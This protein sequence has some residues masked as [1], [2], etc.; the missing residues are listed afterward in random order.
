MI[1][2]HPRRRLIALAILIGASFLGV[3]ARLA[4]LQAFEGEALA[5]QAVEMRRRLEPIRAP[6]GRI[7]DRRGRVLAA[8]RPV[9]RIAL[10]LE[11]LDPGT[12]I[13]ERVA[14][15]WRPRRELERRWRALEER[16][17]RES[18]DLAPLN[19]AA[20]ETPKL[21]ARFR[22]LC[23]EFPGLSF[24]GRTLSVSRGLLLQRARTL[25]RLARA[26]ALDEAALGER[27]EGETE[28]AL[29]IEHPID[30]RERL[31][32]PL[33]VATDI[34]FDTAAWIEEQWR[35]FP[36]VA[37][38]VALEREYPFGSI[39][40][41]LVGYTGP[42]APGDVERLRREGRLLDWAFWR[43]AD[44]AG[45][46]ARREGARFPDDRIGRAGIEASYE[47]I[48][49][50][51][52]GARLVE[53]DRKTREDRTIAEVP[54]VPGTD[55]T[56]A[57][58]LDLQRAAEDALD[59][60][61]A[62]GNGGAHGGALVL[63]DARSGEALALAT[64][65][66][67]DP[68]AIR[69]DYAALLAARPSPLLD[70][71]LAAA[72]PPGSTMKPLVAAAAL[73]ERIALEGG[74]LSPA[75][76]VFCRGH[77][78]NPRAFRCDARSGHGPIA[79]E[80]AIGQSCNVYF[81]K[82]GERL[83]EAGLGT[84][85]ARF[86]L[87]RPTEIDLPGEAAGLLPSGA[88]KR[89]RLEAARRRADREE[90]DLARAGADLAA[91]LAGGGPLAPALTGLAADETAARGGRLATARARRAHLEPEVAW[92]AGDSRNTAIGQ[93]DLLATPIQ[94][95]RAAAALGNGGRLLRPR[96]ARRGGANGEAPAV[97]AV[98]PLAPGTLAAVR[99]GMWAVVASP[100]GTAHRAGLAEFR[101]AGK[102]GTA[103]AGAQGDHAW[104]MGYA[105][106]EAPEV[107]FACLVEHVRPG[108][109]GGDVAA[110]AI[111]RVLAAARGPRKE[112]P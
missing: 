14:R 108:L 5:R 97:E 11:D 57:I 42:L 6:R 59:R 8:D 90:R 60:A 50:G 91:L 112:A 85:G 32:R 41:P 95:A 99:A 21:A 31:R 15:R 79:L 16:A 47:H 45:F 2:P 55:V 34:P 75:T 77:L 69:R 81:F 83:G 43:A 96:V 94:I 13:P 44:L 102:T 110:P 104:F 39:G 63:L 46:A 71:A 28:R 9:Y 111:A 51:R 3:L 98:L 61:V 100:H 105:P 67:Y 49:A 92:G 76:E 18:P 87:G 4:S 101:V 106:L 84:W 25:E 22:R 88:W 27:V 56:L 33:V 40:G 74:P 12:E 73:E 23:E 35:E 20:A 64:A 62:E 80:A 109:A 70:R 29:A 93:G 24:D 78:H 82:V 7:L 66:R 17:R 1:A 107:A 65:P 36:G 72:L 48:L 37:I 38:E 52:P 30:R 26:A 89:R 103:Q 54:A 68:G 10:R 86:G 19:L 53:R 58:D